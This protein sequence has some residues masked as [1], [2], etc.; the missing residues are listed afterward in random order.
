M[1]R[2]LMKD[3]P[4]GKDLHKTLR[5]LYKELH[6]EEELDHV[7]DAVDFVG[8]NNRSLKTFDVNIERSIKM[9]AKLPPSKLKIAESGISDP[10]QVRAF[11]ENGYSGFLIGESFMKDD[12]PGEAF[13][14]FTAKI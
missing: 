5:R 3:H 10:S 6:D 4:D 12:N 8:I 14:N 9:A 11:K 2:A 13:R 7:C 1:I